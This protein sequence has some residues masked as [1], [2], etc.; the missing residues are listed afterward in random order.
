MPVITESRET[1]VPADL[2]SPINHLR[3]SFEDAHWGCG[4]T[5]KAFCYAALHNE[6]VDD[7]AKEHIHYLAHIKAMVGPAATR[8]FHGLARTGAAPS[9]FKAF[10]DLYLNG[11]R[12]QALK[13][14]RDLVEIGRTNEQ[15]L[16]TPHLKWAESQSKQI[17]RSHAYDIKMWVQSVCDQQ[18]YDP[19]DD[20]GELIYWRKWQAPLLVVMTPSRFRPYDAATAWERADAE[21]SMRWLDA[22]AELYVQHLEDAVE[23]AVGDT[24]LEQ[25]KQPR[26][27]E[28]RPA[29]ASSPD[30]PPS[31]SPLIRRSEARRETHKLNTQAKYKSWRT[32]YRKLKKEH[33]G[34]S[35]VWYSQQIAKT[36]VAKKSSAETIRKH[37]RG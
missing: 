2:V 16:G 4:Q 34:M 23:K 14:F 15:R 33:P 20:T 32:A 1:S 19:K 29:V 18:V 5:T 12:V 25:A 6:T 22:F 10:Y 9:V 26:S 36:R 7:P 8:R 37:M 28:D 24:V 21:T 31:A 30:E 35:D 27:A 17:I 11:V 3:K 13:N